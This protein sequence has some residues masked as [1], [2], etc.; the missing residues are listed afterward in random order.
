MRWRHYVVGFDLSTQAQ[1]AR[2]IWRFVEARRARRGLVAQNWNRAAAEQ[3]RRP[4]LSLRAV[5]PVIVVA[6]GGALLLLVASQVRAWRRA[7]KTVMLRARTR[8]QRAAQDLARVLDDALASRGTARPANRSPLAFARELSARGDPMGAVA[9]KVA[10]RYTAARFGD[11]PLR[12][13]ELDALRA[14][15]RA[16][17]DAA[18]RAAHTP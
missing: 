15:L 12:D 6:I 3:A 11:E 14:E 4:G 13:G 10:G 16:A 18:Q 9:L 1:I 8:S 17:R 2:R 7:P 5:R